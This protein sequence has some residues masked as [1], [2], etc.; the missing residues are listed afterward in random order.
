MSMRTVRPSDFVLQFAVFTAEITILQQSA[1]NK[2]R[3]SRSRHANYVPETNLAA[4]PIVNI[5]ACL[6]DDESDDEE[7]NGEMPDVQNDDIDSDDERDYGKL[8]EDAK[9]RFAE[10]LRPPALARASGLAC[11]GPP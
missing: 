8:G 4:P 2:T 1:T 9:D 5:S 11:D 10:G 3:K 7:I 6:L